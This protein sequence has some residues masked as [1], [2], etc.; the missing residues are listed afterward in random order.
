MITLI[1]SIP[2]FGLWLV[3]FAVGAF[4]TDHFNFGGG[5]W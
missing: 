3:A 1:S 4:I 2:F 5:A